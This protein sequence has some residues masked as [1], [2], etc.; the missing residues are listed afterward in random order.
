MTPEE[1][2]E[3]TVIQQYR[4]LLER[5][6]K[7]GDE[8][9]NDEID[10]LIT[11][12]VYAQGDFLQYSEK[13]GVEENRTA[14]LMAIEEVLAQAIKLSETVNRLRFVLDVEEDEAA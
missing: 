9:E 8:I 14:S 2:A 3:L 1:F 4:F 5:L 10:Y 11:L 7:L 6:L 12:L 13:E